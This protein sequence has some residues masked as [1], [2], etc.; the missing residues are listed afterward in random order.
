[1]RLKCED[2]KKKKLGIPKGYN[3]FYKNLCWSCFQERVN[4]RKEKNEKKTQEKI[5]EN[6]S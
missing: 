3:R 1:M 4:K 2:C 6:C 5:R